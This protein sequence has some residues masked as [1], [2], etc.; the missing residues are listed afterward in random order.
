[1]AIAT[2]ASALSCQALCDNVPECATN[3]NYQSSY[4]KDWQSLPVCFGMYSRA[5]GSICYEPNDPTCNDLVLPPV[6]CSSVVS[7]T[8]APVTGAAT[9]VEPTTVAPVV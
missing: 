7:T 3:P 1:M 2:Q 8:S 5:D 4:C 9:T 6:S